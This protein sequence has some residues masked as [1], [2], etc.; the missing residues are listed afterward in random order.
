MNLRTILAAVFVAALMT[1]SAFAA[2]IDGKWTGEMQSPNGARPVTFTFAADGNTLNGSTTGRGGETKI[3]NGKVD[4]DSVTFDVVREMQ[5]NT[6][7][8]HYAGKVSG[9]ELKLAITREG[10][11][12]REVTLKRAK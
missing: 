1:V 4:G 2:T 9:D 7:T 8:M 6:V 10:G 12:P 3:T 5:G 11:E